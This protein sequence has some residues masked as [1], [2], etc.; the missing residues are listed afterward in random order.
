[1]SLGV[2]RKPREIKENRRKFC[3]NSI[4]FSQCKLICYDNLITCC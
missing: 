2:V 1:M 4:D 3:E